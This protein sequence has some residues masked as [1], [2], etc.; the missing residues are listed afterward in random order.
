MNA[1]MIF[2]RKEGKSKKKDRKG[3]SLSL[4]PYN[5]RFANFAWKKQ[6]TSFHPGIFPWHDKNQNGFPG[7]RNHGLHYLLPYIPQ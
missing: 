6:I 4:R 5:I 7:C 1:R 3:V 2:S